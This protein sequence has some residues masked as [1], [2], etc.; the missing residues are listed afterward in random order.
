MTVRYQVIADSILVVSNND[1][2]DTLFRMDR[3]IVTLDEV[4]L[5]DTVA[6]QYYYYAFNKRMITFYNKLGFEDY[7]D[8]TSDDFID[9]PVEVMI[10]TD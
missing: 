8:Y 5:S 9:D 3:A 6:L 7:W 2:S 1:F 4:D 10:I